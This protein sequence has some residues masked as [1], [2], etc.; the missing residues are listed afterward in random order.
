[1][2]ENSL[3]QRQSDGTAAPEVGSRNSVNGGCHPRLVRL[4]VS[5]PGVLYVDTAGVGLVVADMLEE[6]GVSITRLRM[7]QAR[8]LRKARSDDQRE[9]PQSPK[10]DER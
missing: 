6:A 4:L 5:S 10:R 2:S 8:E 1:M 7:E 9:N 3:N